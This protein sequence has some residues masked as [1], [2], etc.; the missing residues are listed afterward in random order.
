MLGA[1][2]FKPIAKNRFLWYTV[3]EKDH[4]RARRQ[5]RTPKREGKGGRLRVRAGARKIRE[6]GEAVR[7]SAVPPV[8]SQVA[9]DIAVKIAAGELKEGERFTGRSLMG[10]QYGVSSETIRRA[11]N[12]LSDLGI[13]EVQATVGSRVLSKKRAMEY[14]EQYQTGKDLRSLKA[15]MA[16][17][18]RQRDALN[19]EINR[20][21][22]QISDLWERFQSSDRFR[23]YEFKVGEDGPAA[24]RTIGELQFRQRTGA[25][26]VAV[27]RKEDGEMELSPGPQ[28]VLSPGDV[29]IVACELSQVEQVRN[30]MEGEKTTG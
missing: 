11:L 30:L 16:E 2:V 28:A 25:T 5:K 4:A 7:R 18:V 15:R 21:F 24:G 26:V 13:I 3:D 12:H 17:L 27:Q 19:E 20:V 10:A 14:V 29:L 1:K 23:T 22:A 6:G 9:F 8:Y